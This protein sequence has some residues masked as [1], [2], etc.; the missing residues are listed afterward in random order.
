M[1]LNIVFRRVGEEMQKYLQTFNTYKYL[2]YNL[3]SRDLTVK[4]RRSVLGFLWSVLNPLLMMI[5]ISA[6]FSYIFRFEI[7]NF[8]VYYL[9]GVTIYNFINEATSLSLSSIVYSESLIK[10]VYIPKYIFPLEKCLFSFVNMLFSLVAVVI[11]M[12]FLGINIT[13]TALLLPFILL[14][15]LLFSF[16]IGLILATATVYFRDVMHLYSVIMMAFMYLTP[17]IYP[18]TAIPE[19]LVKFVMMNPMYYYVEGFR[20]VMIYGVMPPAENLVICAGFGVVALF[21]GLIIFK[22]H[23]DNFILHI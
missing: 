7:E 18:I 13:W 12:I 3:I 19:G 14:T 5:V 2:L 22:K 9:S 21:I 16:G 15:C 17:I 10:K 1:F 11:I 20:D 4:Y 8:Q 6:V 23:Q